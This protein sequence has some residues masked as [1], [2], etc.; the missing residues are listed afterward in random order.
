MIVMIPSAIAAEPTSENSPLIQSVQNALK[1]LETLHRLEEATLSDLAKHAAFTVNQTFRLLATLEHEGY[2]SKT[3]NK[4][5]RLGSK[6]HILG[7]DAHW[8]HALIAAA[9]P[10]MDELAE[11]SSETILLS[12]P[13][14]LERMVVAQKPSRY[15]LQVHYPVGSRIPLYVG[16]MG[17]AMLAFLPETQQRILA[18]P[19]KPF[20]EFTLD[21]TT[22]QKEIEVV[23]RDGYRIS[24]DDYAVGE[25]SVA[26]PILDAQGLAYAAISIAGFSARLSETKLQEYSQAVKT[27]PRTISEQLGFTRLTQSALSYL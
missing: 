24:K 16:G 11:L 15:S 7:K 2:V 17:V 23:R 27:A 21:E 10:V 9:S 1:L 19:L 5:Y 13:S 8:P 6:L 22:L 4:R 18:S 25:F 26:A 20:T 3:I 14:G 12:V